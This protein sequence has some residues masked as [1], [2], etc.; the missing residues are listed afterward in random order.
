MSAQQGSASFTIVLGG[1]AAILVGAI[2]LTF[3][4]YPMVNAFTGS[5]IWSLD[6]TA[7]ANLLTVLEG[8]WTFAGGFML[9]AILSFIWVKT[10]Q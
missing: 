1:L 5:A 4:V 8:V 7:G 6:T 10:R 2:V 3:F 9:I